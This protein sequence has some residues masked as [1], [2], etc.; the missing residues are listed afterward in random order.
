MQDRTRFGIDV[1]SI[2]A[3]FGL[4]NLPPHICFLNNHATC[5]GLGSIEDAPTEGCSEMGSRCELVRVTR[6]LLGNDFRG[7]SLGLVVSS[8]GQRE[9]EKSDAAP[10]EQLSSGDIAVYEAETAAYAAA[11]ATSG[12]GE[13]PSGNSCCRTASHLRRSDCE[14]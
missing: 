14:G 12:A 8:R 9:G 4:S 11:A 1:W 6:K 13:G 3:S 7:Q 2:L 10:A 5:E